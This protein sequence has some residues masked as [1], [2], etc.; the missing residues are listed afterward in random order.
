MNF[1][2]RERM[3]MLFVL[4]R[5]GLVECPSLPA[6]GRPTHRRVA[7]ASRASAAPSSQALVAC[8]RDSVV[9]R[10]DEFRCALCA[11]RAL[12]PSDT[13]ARP[14]FAGVDAPL[15]PN[16]TTLEMQ[17]LRRLDTIG[18]LRNFGETCRKQL[19]LPDRSPR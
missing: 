18:P 19:P 3:R 17:D 4:Y 10:A 12:P 8:V 2:R 7:I 1:I 5:D 16:K 15:E 13:G 6:T 11:S 9:V 14:V